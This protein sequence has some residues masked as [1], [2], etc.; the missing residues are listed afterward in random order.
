MATEDGEA[1]TNPET[2][3]LPPPISPIPLA[4]AVMRLRSCVPQFVGLKSEE[5]EEEE[6]C[7]LLVLRRQ[8][9]VWGRMFFHNWCLE[10]VV[11]A[12]PNDPIA[13]AMV[14]LSMPLPKFARNPKSQQL[15]YKSSHVGHFRWSLFLIGH[16]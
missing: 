5:E 3:S 8:L 12:H 7:D 11:D 4:N 14:S 16:M 2:C 9:K 1:L 6:E 10:A 15:N 13:M